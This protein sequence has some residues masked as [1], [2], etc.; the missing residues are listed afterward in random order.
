VTGQL[1][2][3]PSLTGQAFGN[4]MQGAASAVTGGVV[5]PMSF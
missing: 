5:P 3:L 2:S 4:A 1:P